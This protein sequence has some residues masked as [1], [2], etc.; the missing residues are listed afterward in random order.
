VNGQHHSI[1]TIYQAGI[2]V[3]KNST[4]TNNY[5]TVQGAVFNADNYMAKVE[6]WNT[7]FVNNTAIE[8]GVLNVGLQSVVK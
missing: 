1:F 2:I 3:V 8:G 7:S 5:C 6:V 4:F